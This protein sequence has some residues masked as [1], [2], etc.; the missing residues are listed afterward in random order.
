MAPKNL[1]RTVFH[2]IY[3]Q[4]SM[5]ALRAKARRGDKARSR[6]QT[7]TA[8]PEQQ[9]NSEPSTPVPQQS[10]SMRNADTSLLEFEEGQSELSD[11]VDTT[12]EDTEVFITEF[13]I[14]CPESHAPGVNNQVHHEALAMTM[15][16]LDTIN[17]T[18]TLLQ[19]FEGMSPHLEG[20]KNEMLAKKALCKQ[21]METLKMMGAA[22]EGKER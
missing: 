8:Q 6:S 11:R 16:H 18:L 4:K 22:E 7:P 14:E 3:Q 9:P 15:S 1:L 2:N 10:T 5:E 20:L 12:L 13:D 19:A 21:T 17:T